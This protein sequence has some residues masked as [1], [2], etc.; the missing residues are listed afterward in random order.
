[1][2]T[3]NP[4]LSELIASILAVENNNFYLLAKHSQQ[5]SNVLLHPIFLHLP[6]PTLSLSR[7][8]SL[9]QVHIAYSKDG[10]QKYAVKV[11]HEGLVENANVSTVQSMM[12]V[13]AINHISRF[14]VAFCGCRLFHMNAVL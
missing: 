3:T 9:A 10:K 14:L 4:F 5:S 6:Y 7:V 13:T 12:S 8:A 11:Q 1:L 2:S